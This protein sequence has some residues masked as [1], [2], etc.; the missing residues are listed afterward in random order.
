MPLYPTQQLHRYGGMRID[1]GG[2]PDYLE[3]YALPDGYP[4]RKGL[5][6]HASQRHHAVSMETGLPLIAILGF[7]AG[8]FVA[9]Q[10]LRWIALLSVVTAKQ[11]GDFLGPPRRRLLW[12]VPFVVILHPALYI[13]SALLV[14]TILGLFHRLA[15]GWSWFLVGLY[16]YVIV[17]GLSIVSRYRRIRRRSRKT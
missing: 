17:T 1:C 4:R 10:V 3:C 7:V 16:I 12:A 11:G 15:G 6:R 2:A 14:I 9:Q 8:S 5:E 13:I